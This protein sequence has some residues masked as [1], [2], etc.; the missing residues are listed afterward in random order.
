MYQC[1]FCGRKSNGMPL[2]GRIMLVI[3]GIP[4]TFQGVWFLGIPLIGL[5][6]FQGRKFARCPKCGVVVCRDH[7]APESK[8]ARCGNGVLMNIG[9][10]A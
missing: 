2:F 10:S 5:A 8:C 6:I 4:M 9:R 1:D 7:G 3:L